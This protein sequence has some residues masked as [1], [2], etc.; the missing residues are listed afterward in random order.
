MTLSCFSGFSVIAIEE[1]FVV[2][3]KSAGVGMHD[4]D[5]IEGLVSLARRQLAMEL[6]PVH[7][8]DK[9]TS[10]VLLLARNPEAN[11]TLSMAFAE[12]QM[13]K[14]YVALSRHKPA[15]KQGWVKGDMARGRRGGW[16][17]QRSMIN[18]AI[19]WFQSRSVDG[20]AL[21]L[22]HVM[23]KTGK[24]HQIRVALKSLGAPILGDET[25]AGE[26]SDRVYLH[27]LALSFCYGEQPWC[28]TALPEVG[29]WFLS[30]A[31]LEQLA[32]LQGAIRTDG[33]PNENKKTNKINNI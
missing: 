24:T 20:S 7:R 11:R 30:P 17:L 26:R 21:R 18:P 1:D 5:G 3:N 25:Y 22:F 32:M 33:V 16:L 31:T 9:V 10:G 23:P 13:T 19:T 6:Y 4:E 28:F 29:E 14:H 2:L 27:A 8:L 12:R 15:K